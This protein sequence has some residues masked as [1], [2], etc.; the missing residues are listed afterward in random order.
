M[1]KS[2]LRQEYNLVDAQLNKAYGEAYRYIEQVPRTGAK[3]LDTEQLNLLKKS[4]RAWL[5]FRDK[6]CELILS[7]EDVQ[8]LSD[9]YSESEWLSCM[10]IQTNTRTRQLQLY[11]NSEDFYPSPLTRG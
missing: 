1:I 4:Q 11:R 7:N 10:I 6:E 5:D 3:K 2:C 8:D 9:P